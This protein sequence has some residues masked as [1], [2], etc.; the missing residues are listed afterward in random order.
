MTA[1]ALALPAAGEKS[2]A[3]AVVLPEVVPGGSRPA[4]GQIARQ[5]SSSV[6]SLV[7]AMC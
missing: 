2:W 3:D 1:V 4:S 7:L 5:S 6:T